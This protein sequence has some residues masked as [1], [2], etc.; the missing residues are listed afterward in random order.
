MRLN[1]LKYSLLLMM[2]A[3]TLPLSAQK[4]VRKN[5][6]KGNKAY[7]QQKFSEAFTFYNDALAENPSSPE[8]NYNAG[9][10]LYRQKEWDKSME[11]YQQYLAL[12]KENPKKCR[13]PG[14]ISEIHCCKRKNW[15]N[16]WRLTRWLFG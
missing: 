8:A 2:M 12:E 5:V 15:K 4:E 3:L 14:T 11:S 10:T 1:I 6:R 16:R 9:N 13:L 7:Q